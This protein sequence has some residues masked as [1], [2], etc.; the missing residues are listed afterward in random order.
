MYSLLI[1]NCDLWNCFCMRLL[2]D[3]VMYVFSTRCRKTRAKSLVFSYI[4]VKKNL[5][6]ARKVGVGF[7]LISLQF[8]KKSQ[9][10]IECYLHRVHYTDKNTV[11]IICALTNNL[12]KYSINI[13][14]KYFTWLWWKWG[15]STARTGRF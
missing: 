6:S 14:F 12:K 4:F 7:I 8:V 15:S 9:K 10:N 1:L 2:I 11:Q 3:I 13:F 5:F